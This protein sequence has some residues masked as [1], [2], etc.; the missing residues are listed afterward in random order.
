MLSIDG[1]VGGEKKGTT[2][3]WKPGAIFLSS[4]I[5]EQARSVRQNI[6]RRF[7]CFL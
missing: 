3:D 1:V 2:D 5:V 4:A 6:I 7:F